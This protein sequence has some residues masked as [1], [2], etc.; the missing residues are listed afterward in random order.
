MLILHN[1][2]QKTRK[3]RIL[4]SLYY[5]AHITL[6]IK[7]EKVQKRKLQTKIFYKLRWK[8]PYLPISKSNKTMYKKNYPPLPNEIDS[9]YSSLLPCLKISQCNWSH[10]QYKEKIYSFINWFRESIWDWK[11]LMQLGTKEN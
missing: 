11:T 10:Q 4:P 1:L 5:E 7:P 9:R 8:S 3:E 2:F 6:I